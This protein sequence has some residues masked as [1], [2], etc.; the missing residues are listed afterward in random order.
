MGPAGT[1]VTDAVT[2]PCVTGRPRARGGRQL[3]GPA[4]HTRTTVPRPVYVVISPSFHPAR[5]RYPGLDA[6]RR[7]HKVQ[8]E[9]GRQLYSLN[10]YQWRVVVS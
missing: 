4:S 6:D 3:T 8:A 9:L 7:P 2:V 10:P 5:V 1:G